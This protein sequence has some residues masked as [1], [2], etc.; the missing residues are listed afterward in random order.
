MQLNELSA[1]YSKAALEWIHEGGPPKPN[2]EEVK[3]RF[4]AKYGKWVNWDNDEWE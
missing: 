1:P 3:A 4:L 2:A